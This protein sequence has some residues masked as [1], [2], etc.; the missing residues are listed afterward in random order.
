MPSGAVSVPN[1]RRTE[2]REWSLGAEVRLKLRSM[3][4]AGATPL[5]ARLSSGRTK[6]PSFPSI[7]ILRAQD[8][9]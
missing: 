9:F 5:A 6:L 8:A 2:P 4:F 3:V 7:T 1:H